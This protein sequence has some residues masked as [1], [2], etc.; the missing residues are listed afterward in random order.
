MSAAGH[1]VDSSFNILHLLIHLT[2]EVTLSHMTD[3][4]GVWTNAIEAGT[5]D[6]ATTKQYYHLRS[7]L[8]MISGK[9]YLLI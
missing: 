9:F 1:L 7:L 8:D 2:H 6:L 4:L 5:K 3:R